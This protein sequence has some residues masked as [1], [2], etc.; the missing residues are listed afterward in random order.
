MEK[1]K[2]LGLENAI[3]RYAKKQGRVAKKCL[4]KLARLIVEGKII[5]DN[6]K[7][8]AYITEIGTL[9]AVDGSFIIK[10]F[11]LFNEIGLVQLILRVN[12]KMLDKLPRKK[13][14]YLI[15]NGIEYVEFI[16]HN[17]V[18]L[19]RY[20]DMYLDRLHKY[21]LK[22][23]KEE[24]KNKQVQFSFEDKSKKENN[25]TKAGKSNKLDINN[26]QTAGHLYKTLLMVKLKNTLHYAKDLKIFWFNLLRKKETLSDYLTLMRN[27]D[28]LPESHSMVAK[29]IIARRVINQLNIMSLNKNFKNNATQTIKVSG[30]NI[31]YAHTLDGYNGSCYNLHGHNGKLTIEITMD[32][33]HGPDGFLFDFKELKSKIKQMIDKEYDHKLLIPVSR[34][35]ISTI[36]FTEDFF[37]YSRPKSRNSDHKLHIEESLYHHKRFRT[38]KMVPYEFSTTEYMVKYSLVPDIFTYVIVPLLYNEKT[39]DFTRSFHVKVTFCESDNNCITEEFRYILDK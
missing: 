3:L 19:Y 20:L 5:V 22:Q 15:I 9:E 6:V 2:L 31:P 29:N 27:L 30:F 24:P 36:Y 37:R 39:G 21:Q 18:R 16:Y 8:T 34:N 26:R 11:K 7:W 25:T 10:D 14:R 1:K 35:R 32:S 28:K 33:K 4:T 17:G 12:N 13:K 23:E 38:Y